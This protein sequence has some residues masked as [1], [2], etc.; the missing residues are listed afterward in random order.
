MCAVLPSHTGGQKDK[1]MIRFGEDESH[2]KLQIKKGDGPLP[3]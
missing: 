2:I 3:H 1:D